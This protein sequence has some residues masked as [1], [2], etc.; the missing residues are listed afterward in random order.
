MRTFLQVKYGLQHVFA[1][2][3]ITNSG[4]RTCTYKCASIIDDHVLFSSEIKS[5]WKIKHIFSRNKKFMC[6]I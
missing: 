2:I 3:I 5:H 6:F 4:L 1:R